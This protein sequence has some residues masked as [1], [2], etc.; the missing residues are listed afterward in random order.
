MAALLCAEVRPFVFKLALL[1]LTRSLALP[2][3]YSINLKKA[4]LSATEKLDAYAQTGSYMAQKYFGSPSRK[5]KKDQANQIFGLD[6]EGKP[7]YGVPLSNYMNAQVGMNALLCS[8]RNSWKCGYL[9]WTLC[10]SMLFARS[11]LSL[12]S[13]S[14]VCPL[15]FN[16]HWRASLSLSP[17]E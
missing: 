8:G 11:A 4:D 10:R 5:M 15:R 6:A 7:S 16:R 2:M 9:S 13:L 3:L 12:F 17:L 1:W 14:P